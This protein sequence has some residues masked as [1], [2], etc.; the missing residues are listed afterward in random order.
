MTLRAVSFNSTLQ[1]MDEALASYAFS[2]HLI[3][4]L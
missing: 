4:P 1:I 3:C 2:L